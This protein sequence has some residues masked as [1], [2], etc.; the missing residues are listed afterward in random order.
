MLRVVLNEKATMSVGGIVDAVQAR[1]YLAAIRQ[2]PCHR[3]S[4]ADQGITIRFRR[5]RDVSAEKVIAGPAS[6]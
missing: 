3:Q 5:S 4:D 6:Y 1:G 2:L